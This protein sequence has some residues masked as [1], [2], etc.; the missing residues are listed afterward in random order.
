MCIFGK[1]ISVMAAFVIAG[2]AYVAPASAVID[3]TGCD[4]ENNLYINPDL[5]LCS[6]HVYNIGKTENPT[7]SSERQ[8]MQDVVALKTTLMTQQM[9]SQYEI[10]ATTVKR[11]RTQLQKEIL[12]AKLKTTS[13]AANGGSYNGA[14]NS[15]GGSSSAAPTALGQDCSGKS[16]MDTVYCLR[17]NYSL[18]IAQANSRS[19]TKELKQ[20]IVRDRNAICYMESEA[21]LCKGAEYEF[22]KDEKQLNKETI[23]TCLGAISGAINKL[24]EGAPRNNSQQYGYR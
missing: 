18:M 11:L 20:Q 15:G 8:L 12:L 24:E 21:A 3:N 7:N 10:L 9:Y 19:Y 13:A 16:R 22:C 2:G 1:I 6:T 5:A 23:P 4:R 14:G 17:N